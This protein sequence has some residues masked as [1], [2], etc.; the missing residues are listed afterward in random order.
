MA[1]NKEKIQFEVDTNFIISALL[2][3]NSITAR[4]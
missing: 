1:R 4:F 2:K 3:Y